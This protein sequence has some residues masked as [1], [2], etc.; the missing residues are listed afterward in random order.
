MALLK[1]RR[2]KNRHLAPERGVRDLECEPMV[3]M[4]VINNAVNLHVK[5][6]YKFIFYD[7][8]FGVRVAMRQR[9]D[10]V[11]ES[12]S[13]ENVEPPPKEKKVQLPGDLKMG[14]KKQAKLEEKARKK[15]AREEEEQMREER[16]ALELM[17]DEERKQL[18]E[19][20]KV[21]AV[22]LG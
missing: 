1:R 17:K 10:F 20:E 2:L 22:Y 5:F 7:T 3:I 13:N 4:N 16:R 9:Q 11:E 18:S 15:A 12:S 21:I 6:L 19:K 14:A 8:K